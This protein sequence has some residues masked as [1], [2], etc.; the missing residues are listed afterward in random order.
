MLDFDLNEP[1][2]EEE[3]DEQDDEPFIG[4][5]FESED[6]AF[7]FYNNYAKQH[8]FVVRKDRSDTRNGRTI[9]RDILCHRAGKQRL[10]V[11]DHF[12][13]QRNKKSSKCDC[14]AHMRITLKRSF[15]IFPEEWHVTK[16]I[17]LHN[18][19]MIS[20]EAMRFLPTNRTITSEDE[21]QILMY[22]EAG[23][24]VRQIIKV[25]ELQKNV[26]H[27]ELSFIDK[28]VRNLFDRVKRML[29]ANDAKDL[30]DY[31]KSAKQEN[32]MFQYVFTL[33]GYGRLEHLFWCQAQSFDCCWFA[34]LLR[35]DYKNWCAS[36]YQSYKMTVPEDFE[37]NWTL[38]VAKF[39]LQ[40][41]RHIKASSIGKEVIDEDT[42][43]EDEYI[44]LSNTLGGG[45]EVLPP[46]QSK[47]K[48][49]PRKK[50]DK[51]GKEL[52]KK[53]TKSCSICKQSGHTKPTC[54]SN[55]NIVAVNN[56]DAGTSFISQ[57]RK[58][59]AVDT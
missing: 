40:D 44:P 57:K 58:K 34:A 4:Q 55:E 41:N 19:G 26:K 3:N 46:L 59:I 11:A 27:G 9:R 28:D 33:D 47:K 17:N 50:R 29:G 52:G 14:K 16:F 49:R 13:P 30:V 23:L 53:L 32:K 10:K 35:N 2:M 43:P 18:H 8:G 7:V 48:G 21:K 36:I 42:L 38:M 5:T 45:D 6:E 39:K 20:P 24:Q 54:P 56:M 25:M 1:L 12:K 15:D 37:H 51:G 31:M 22:K